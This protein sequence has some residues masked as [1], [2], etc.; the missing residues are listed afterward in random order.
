M[1]LSD[2]TKENFQKPEQL[3]MNE[4]Q[5]RRWKGRDVAYAASPENYYENLALTFQMI[6]PKPK[7]TL[8]LQLIM[9]LVV[10]QRFL[11]KPCGPS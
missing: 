5:R 11:R 6:S 9:L 7:V 4:I 1:Y 8:S 10:M 2:V 3:S